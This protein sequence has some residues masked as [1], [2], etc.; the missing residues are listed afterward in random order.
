[1]AYHGLPWAQSQFFGAQVTLTG[2]ATAT[3]FVVYQAERNVREIFHGKIVG[4]LW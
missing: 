4:T 1:M 3:H 2:G